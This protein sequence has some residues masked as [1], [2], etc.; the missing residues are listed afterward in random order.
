MYKD[1]VTRHQ[2]SLTKILTIFPPRSKK[3][4]NQSPNINSDQ[5]VFFMMVIHS[6][7]DLC[8]ILCLSEG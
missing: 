6:F 1:G 5:I 2:L 7:A 3:A 4:M 8:F